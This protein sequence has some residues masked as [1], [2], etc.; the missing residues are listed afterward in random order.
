M[1]SLIVLVF[2]A[3]GEP[4]KVIDVYQLQP[5]AYRACKEK[6]KELNKSALNGR[7]DCSVMEKDD[8]KLFQKKG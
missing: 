1:K 5:G 2:I 8:P 7:W 3:F 4:P 6:A